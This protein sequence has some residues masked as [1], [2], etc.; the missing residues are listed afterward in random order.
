M[1]GGALSGLFAIAPK[2]A[3]CQVRPPHNPIYGCTL[4][5]DEA[6]RFLRDASDQTTAI[7]GGEAMI[8]HS[9]DRDFDEALAET[10]LQISDLFAVS[11]SFAY[12]NDPKANAYATKDVRSY[13]PDGSVLFGLNLRRRFM[14]D[15]DARDAAVACVCA[16]EFG[17]ILQYKHG[18]DAKLKAGQP[19]VKRVE[20]QA[21]FFA[22]YYAGVRR[23]AR[24]NF[25]SEIFGMTQYNMGDAWVDQPEHHGTPEER[26]DAITQGFKAGFEGQA[27]SEAIQNS[28]TYAS[29]L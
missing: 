26:G 29:S 1:A 25:P 20:L 18:L 12:Y 10:L 23:R 11:P 17:H 4:P 28:M 14:A 3:S 8:S 9:E 21:D 7:T 19:T 22:G 16:H 13:G 24:S 6:S 27:I 2:T 5:H 15:A